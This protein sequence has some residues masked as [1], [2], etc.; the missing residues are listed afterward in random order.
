MVDPIEELRQID[1]DHDAVTV[2]HMLLRCQHGIPHT[3]AGSEPRGCV[4]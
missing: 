2:L 1:V 3:T 4:H